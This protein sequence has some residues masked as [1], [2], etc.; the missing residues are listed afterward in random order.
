MTTS[1]VKSRSQLG[2][3]ALSLHSIGPR[4]SGAWNHD[5]DGY[6]PRWRRIWD[7]LA[8]RRQLR[9]GNCAA[10][11]PTRDEAAALIEER[12]G[13]VS[14]SVSNKTDYVVAGEDAGSKL[15]KAES[16]GVTILNEAEFAG[17]L[18]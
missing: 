11:F 5:A 15:T 14:S 13:R 7:R 17:M 4:T 16:L 9:C 18:E 8:R 10:S 12:G 1:S 6:W 3:D 2:L